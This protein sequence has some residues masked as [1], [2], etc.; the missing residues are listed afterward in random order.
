VTIGAVVLRRSIAHQLA[1]VLNSATHRK[2]LMSKYVMRSHQFTCWAGNQLRK[3][4]NSCIHQHPAV[5]AWRTL[6]VPSTHKH[7]GASTVLPSSSLAAFSVGRPASVRAAAHSSMAAP[8]TE[9]TL[10]DEAVTMCQKV[11][12]I[13]D[14]T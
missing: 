4:G 8:Q 10:Q 7:S 11:S 6:H 5:A 13:W 9:K 14:S 1:P 2:K 12:Q 3:C